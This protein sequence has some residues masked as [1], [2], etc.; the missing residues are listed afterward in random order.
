MLKGTLLGLGLISLLIGSSPSREANNHNLKPFQSPDFIAQIDYRTTENSQKINV[1]VQVTLDRQDKNRSR[2]IISIP[3]SAQVEANHHEKI[4]LYRVVK[5][6]SR[7]LEGEDL[8]PIK[9]YCL[10]HYHQG[11]PPTIFLLGFNGG[12]YRIN[13]V[14]ISDQIKQPTPWI[15]EQEMSKVAD[16][17]GEKLAREMEFGFLSD[18]SLFITKI[19]IIGVSPNNQ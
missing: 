3:R 17:Y 14:D 18:L 6:F 9:I 13:G 11:L 4:A 8:I 7:F 15:S 19:R 16:Y 10:Q 5:V 1:S 2:L 12:P